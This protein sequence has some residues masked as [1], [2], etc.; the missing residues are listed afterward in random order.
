M[1]PVTFAQSPAV[2][3]ACHRL[4]RTQ[5]LQRRQAEGPG[6]RRNG[7][8][9]PGRR[10]GAHRRR[11]HLPESDL[12]QVVRRLR[13]GD[14]RPDQ[15]PVDRLGRRHPPVHRGHRGLRRHRRPDVDRADGRG[16]GQRAP[17]PDRARRRRADL[18]P[19]RRSAAAKLVLD[20]DAIADIFLGRITKWNDPKLAALNPGVKLPNTDIIVV[21]RS[22]GSGTS[23][24]LHRLPDQGVAG[25]EGEGRAP[26]RR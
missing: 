6:C 8:T 24:H 3:P 2:R 26:P 7:R 1:P 23:V 21:H 12:H 15:L 17:R 11:R 5:R 16:E 4:G 9:R 10:R 20:G 14:R 13:Q 19:A 22:D 18:Q 25:V